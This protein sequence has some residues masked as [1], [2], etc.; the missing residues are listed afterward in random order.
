MPIILINMYKGRTMEKK[1]NLVKAVTDAVE[2]SLGVKRSD[3]RIILREMD[4]EDYAIAGTL[5]CDE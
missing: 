3:V 1:R 2:E 5:V 4:K